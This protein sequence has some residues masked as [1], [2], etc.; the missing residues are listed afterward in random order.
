M[1]TQPLHSDRDMAIRSRIGV[2][3][4]VRKLRLELS[5]SQA[6][7]AERVGLTG[8]MVSKIEN[9]FANL[10]AARAADFAKALAIDP[11]Q[12]GLVLLSHHDPYIFA[13]VFPRAALEPVNVPDADMKRALAVLERKAS[14]KQASRKRRSSA[15]TN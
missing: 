4:Y 3:G 11:Q 12:F 10:P 15:G 2:G 1:T 13:M 7:L 8:D 6:D 14:L 9:G 5:L